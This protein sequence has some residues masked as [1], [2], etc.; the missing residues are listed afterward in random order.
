MYNLYMNNIYDIGY[1]L[2]LVAYS[3]KKE[4]KKIEET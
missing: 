4:K 2:Q 1:I 3:E